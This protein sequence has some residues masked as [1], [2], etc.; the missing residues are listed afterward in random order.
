MNPTQ[1]SYIEMVDDGSTIRAELSE[2]ADCP[3]CNKPLPIGEFGVC[4]ARPSGRNLYCKACIRKKVT[5]SR[6]RLR[7]YRDARREQAA[8][9]KLP[10]IGP[11][12]LP[13]R[14]SGILEGGE[15]RDSLYPHHERVLGAIHSGARTQAEILRAIR[16]AH[17]IASEAVYSPAY[18]CALD[19]LGDSLAIL[20]LGGRKKI[21]TRT[22]G[23]AHEYFPA[24]P[25]PQSHVVVERE[26]S[27]ASLG[28]IV[29]PIIRGRAA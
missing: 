9:Q 4:N 3:V 7:V 2:T 29:A 11:V 26:S 16:P 8:Q 13:A 24:D 10:L 12:P 23:D 22:V 14:P 25:P 27:F 21:R 15:I 18:Q 17:Q 28:G 1:P 19:E 20:L 6:R 5:E